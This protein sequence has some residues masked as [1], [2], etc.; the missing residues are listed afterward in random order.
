MFFKQFPK[1]TYSIENDA[2]R[3]EITDYFRYVD[4]VE[5]FADDLYSYQK[6]DIIDGII[7]II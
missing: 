2:I 3:T 1:T 4:V 7:Y 5:K 6:V